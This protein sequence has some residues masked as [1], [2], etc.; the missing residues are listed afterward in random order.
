MQAGRERNMMTELTPGAILS[1]RYK[2]VEKIGRGGM[3]EVWAGQDLTLGRTVAVKVM[4]PQFAMDPEFVQRFKREAASAANLSNPYIVNVY[5][6]GQDGAIQY[7]VM[8]YVAGE[9]LK[10]FIQT[11]GIL[12]TKS[13]AKIGAQVCKALSSAH[14]QDIVHR[15]VKPQNIMIT[16][17]GSVKVMD[18]GISRAKNS[19]DQ[20]TQ[21]VLGTAQYVSPEQA[22]GL[23]IS[24]AS[25]IYSLGI[26]LYEAVTGQLPFNGEDAVSVA[27]KQVEEPPV[28]PSKLNPN[29]DAAFESII[30]KALAKEPEDRFLTVQDMEVTLDN[31]ANGLRD[32]SVAT[33]QAMRTNDPRANYAAAGATVAMPGAPAQPADAP[34]GKGSKRGLII[35]C[36]VGGVL[37]LAAIIAFV[38]MFV[39]AKVN[40]PDVSG[41]KLEAAITMIEQ[42]GLSAGDIIEVPSKDIPEGHVVSTDPEAGAEVDKGTAIAIQVSSGPALVKVPD[43]SG[44]TE[45]EAKAALEKAG[46][47]AEQGADEASPDVEK[48]RVTS[49][50]PASGREV[51]AGSAVVYHISSGTDTVE[52]PDLSN[53]DEQTALKLLE[54]LGLKGLVASRQASDTVQEGY[55]ISQNPAKDLKVDLG[56]QV[57]FT[58]STGVAEVTVPALEGLTQTAARSTLINAGLVLGTVTEEYS[59]EQKGTVIKQSVN[60][61]EKAKK[62]VSIDIVVSKGPEPANENS[63][64]NGHGDANTQ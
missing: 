40:V 55:V 54:Q 13:A 45:D 34:S 4:L 23:P 25:D 59:T 9:D 17:Q 48:G 22:Q 60:N 46:L 29:V 56:S 12:P 41:N 62:G 42:S 2:L 19:T 1:Q 63:N 26:V 27:L 58:V 32:M 39:L 31:Y 49:Q 24:A 10:H 28:P 16:P 43:L 33:T 14:H 36:A 44:L 51:E 15:D 21:V 57:T 53:L 37:L 7:M 6:W 8:E 52:V 11:K 38:F 64:S 61:G 50:S 35:G 18:F 20:K 30:L 5:D 47:K 3:A